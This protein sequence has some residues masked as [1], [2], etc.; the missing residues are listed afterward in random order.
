MPVTSKKSLCQTDEDERLQTTYFLNPR[1][2]LGDGS[3]VKVKEKTKKKES[4]ELGIEKECRI[5]SNF[6]YNTKYE[7][8]FKRNLL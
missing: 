6:T 7:V 4:K 5:E 1:P 3:D 2:S 8:C